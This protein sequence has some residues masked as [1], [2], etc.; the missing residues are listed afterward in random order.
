MTS[1]G[2][3]RSC[4]AIPGFFPVCKTGVVT[5]AQGVARQ[6]DTLPTPS[7][8]GSTSTRS[9]GWRLPGQLFDAGV[10]ATDVFAK[11]GDD[12]GL[13]QIVR[14]NP[15]MVRRHDAHHIDPNLIHLVYEPFADRHRWTIVGPL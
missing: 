3:S 7:S 6:L 4:A 2:N 10:A 13:A 14:V 1:L 11:T 9:R 5:P 12:R 8:C 15:A